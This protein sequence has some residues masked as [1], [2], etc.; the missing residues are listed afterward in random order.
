[1][2]DRSG[3]RDAAGARVEL[4][5]SKAQERLARKLS[6]CTT[7]ADLITY[8]SY[9]HRLADDLEKQ[10]KLVAAAQ[11]KVDKKQAMLID[12]LKARKILDK[13]KEKQSLAYDQRL[14]RNEQI[15][16]NEVAGSRHLR[17]RRAGK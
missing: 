14:T 5:R 15:F 13:L 10:K 9:L 4:L 17:R 6:R 12:A 16:M 11:Q 2:L 8:Q 1:M 3:R 7:A